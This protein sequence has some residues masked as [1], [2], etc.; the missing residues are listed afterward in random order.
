M[1]EAKWR[2]ASGESPQQVSGS[3]GPNECAL[4]KRLEVVKYFEKSRLILKILRAHEVTEYDVWF[5][6]SFLPQV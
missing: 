5:A 2:Q 6:A 4:R 3:I 1:E